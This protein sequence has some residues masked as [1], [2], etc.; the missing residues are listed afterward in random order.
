MQVEFK[1]NF[2]P[3]FKFTPRRYLRGW[4]GGCEGF[5]QKK[6]PKLGRFSYRLS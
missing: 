5:K 3:E 6:R 4:K 1:N 2:T